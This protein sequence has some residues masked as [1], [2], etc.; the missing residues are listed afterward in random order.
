MLGVLE[1]WI[2]M[3]RSLAIV[4]VL[5]GC[6]GKDGDA[7]TS[8]LTNVSLTSAG[9]GGS[10]TE[11]EG[12]GEGPGNG[13]AGSEDGPD[14]SVDVKFDLGENSEFCVDK[15]AGIYCDGTVAVECDGNGGATS[16]NNCPPAQCQEGEGCVTCLAGEFACKGPRVMSCDT[17]GADPV[18]EEIDV[19]DAAAGMVCD[20]PS[21]S[22]VPLSPIGG[23][24]PT[25]EYYQYAVFDLTADGFSSI[26]DVDS[27][28]NRIYFVA[29]QGATLTIGRYDVELLDSDADGQ[30]EPNQHPDNPEEP[31]PIEERVFTFVESFPAVNPGAFPNVMELYA[32][33]D[34]IVYSGMVDV[35]EH[36]LAT[37]AITQ[38][39][40]M[41]TWI[42]TTSYNWL[43]F[44]GY[45]DINGVWYSGNESARRVFQ[46]DAESQTWGY[47]F[48]FPILAG[49][50]MDGLEVVTDQST[51][52]PYVYVSDMTSNFIGQYRHDP[53]LGWVQENLFS[54]VETAGAPLEGFGFGALNH[55]WCGS[56][57]STFYELGGGDIQQFVD[58]PG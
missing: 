44:L 17:T 26:S 24:E 51:G 37:D 1:G 12:P 15:S 7:Q 25:G 53:D 34:S 39:A 32:K 50:H 57:Y 47:A 16:T 5:A 9:T 22:C 21:G 13:P 58:P 2:P 28:D 33:D 35:R 46:Y 56:L 31:G 54:Y 10:E 45:D 30:L 20:A 18:W 48:E 52:T 19:C 4:V 55:F 29:M 23:I 14:S 3:K 43:A 38:V 27:I 11:G 49:D 6:G 41:P 40:P 36:D 8:A 42:A